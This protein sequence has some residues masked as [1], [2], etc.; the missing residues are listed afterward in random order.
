MSSHPS[1]NDFANLVSL[2]L[3]VL[4]NAVLCMYLESMV[5]YQN[6]LTCHLVGLKGPKW[7]VILSGPYLYPHCCFLGR[8]NSTVPLVFT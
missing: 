3:K 8:E 7:L 6:Y 4:R 2:K 5:E 1:L